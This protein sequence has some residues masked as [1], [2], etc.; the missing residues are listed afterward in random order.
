[1]DFEKMSWFSRR[2][3]SKVKNAAVPLIKPD[4]T[5]NY[6]IAHY[7]EVK[8]GR[9]HAQAIASLLHGPGA[10]QVEVRQAGWERVE[11]PAEQ[12]QKRYPFDDNDDDDDS[13][14]FSPVMPLRS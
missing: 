4:N 1:M 3:S 2:R 10:F 12:P 13:S 8:S 14:P 9:N 5:T 11:I 7:V 6:I